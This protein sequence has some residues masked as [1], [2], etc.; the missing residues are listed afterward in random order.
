MD[1]TTADS[2]ALTRDNNKKGGSTRYYMNEDKKKVE[3][4]EDVYEKLKGLPEVVTNLVEELKIERKAKQ[5][6]Q[7]AA[8]KAIA[9]AAALPEPKPEDQKDA[10]TVVREILAQRDV[11]DAKTVRE[12]AERKFKNS[13]KEF[14]PE[15]DPAGIKYSA[16][17]KVLARLNTTGLTSEEAYQSVF[18]DA[19]TLMNRQQTNQEQ[20]ITPYA[21]TPVD[22]GTPR[23]E[24]PNGLSPKEKKLIQGLGWTEEKYLKLKKSRPAYVEQMLTYAK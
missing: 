13:H 20:I 7:D 4:D 5:E 12:N 3:I 23:H 21:D 22:G 16:F 18:N 15:N 17:E 10:A 6:A 11:D 9:D 14:H 24:D 8:A 2:T 1:S 19:L